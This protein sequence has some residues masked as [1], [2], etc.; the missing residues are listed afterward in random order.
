M[1]EE[2]CLRP[3]N[4]HRTRKHQ[5]LRNRSKGKSSITSVDDDT[6]DDN[7]ELKFHKPTSIPWNS[8]TEGITSSQCDSALQDSVNGE[9]FYDALEEVD[10]SD[11][12]FFVNIGGFTNGSDEPRTPFI[13]PSQ[14]NSDA[15]RERLYRNTD[16]S[17]CRVFV[18]ESEDDGSRPTDS[19]FW[20]N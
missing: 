13:D 16:G 6:D 4:T 3:R 20:D 9:I 10:A 17:I 7:F 14:G 1:K 2:D 18:S 11:Y 8:T 15:H 5:S 12:V 19:T